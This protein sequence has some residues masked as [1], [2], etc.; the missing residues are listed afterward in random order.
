MVMY[1]LTEDGRALLDSV[2]DTS[3]ST[4]T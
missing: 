4:R 1:T 2:V 3:S